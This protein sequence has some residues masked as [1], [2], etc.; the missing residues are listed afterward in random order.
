MNGWLRSGLLLLAIAAPMR[1]ATLTGEIV[2]T[3][4]YA[5][6]QIAGPAHTA[7]ALKCAKAGMPLALLDDTTHRVYLLLPEKDAGPLPPA[8]VAMA[9]KRVSIDGDVLPTHG[10]LFLRVKGFK[11]TR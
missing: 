10:V 1:A 8:L 2:D 7:C 6:S 4:C 11:S 3:F 5:N 9:G